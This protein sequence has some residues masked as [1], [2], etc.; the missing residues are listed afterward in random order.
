MALQE[1]IV[2]GV[3]GYDIHVV[4]NR[5]LTSALKEAGFQPYNL[6][7]NNQPD[8]FVYAA[9]EVEANSVLVSSLNGEGEYWCNGFRQ[10]FNKIGREDILLYAGGN[11]TVGERPEEEVVSLFKSFGFDRVFYKTSDFETVLNV[12]RKDLRDG[13]I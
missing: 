5:I 6:G 2:L 8:D 9:L 1:R 4:A 11:L 12:L 13:H 10:R 3:I 7:P